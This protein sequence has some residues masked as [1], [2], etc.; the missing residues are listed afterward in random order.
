MCVNEGVCCICEHVKCVCNSVI[1][2]C[3]WKM[4]YI[5]RILCMEE[6]GIY[7]C[8]TEGVC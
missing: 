4:V 6:L 5:A 2:M 7:M 1:C 8:V 3:V